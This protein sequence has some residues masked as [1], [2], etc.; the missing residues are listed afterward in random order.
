MCCIYTYKCWQTPKTKSKHEITQTES[1]I[2]QT[3][4]ENMTW[5]SKRANL[6][7]IMKMHSVFQNL[8][9]PFVF[10]LRACIFSFFL[11]FT[12]H[13]HFFPA[14]VHS[15]IQSLQT[16]PNSFLI[17]LLVTA[18]PTPWHSYMDNREYH[19]H[20]TKL[21]PIA[22]F[23]AAQLFWRTISFKT[24]HLHVCTFLFWISILRRTRLPNNSANHIVWLF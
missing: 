17:T 4:I 11:W 1:K 18:I 2:W 6:V 3:I 12:V 13:A 24:L 23:I 20:A 5:K 16:I 14:C 15:T 10:F 19:N 9:F 21:L 22:K 8:F 7:E